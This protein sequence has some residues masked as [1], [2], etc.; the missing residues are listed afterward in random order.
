MYDASA[1]TNA[2]RGPRTSSCTNTPARS[3]IRARSDCGSVVER[4]A[5]CRDRTAAAPMRGKSRNLTQA[6]IVNPIK[7]LR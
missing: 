5:S 7:A 1:G 6:E 3:R 2:A 4:C